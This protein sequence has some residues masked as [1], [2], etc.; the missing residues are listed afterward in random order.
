MWDKS[1][2]RWKQLTCGCAKRQNLKSKLAL[3]GTGGSPSKALQSI[4]LK[5]AFLFGVISYELAESSERF[6]RII[7]RSKSPIIVQYGNQTI[8]RLLLK[9][10]EGPY[11]H[12]LPICL[13]RP[14]WQKG[15]ALGQSRSL[16][17][18]FLIP[19]LDGPGFTKQSH[20]AMTIQK[21]KDMLTRGRLSW[22]K[23]G[24]AYKGC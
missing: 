8:K 3:S 7:A 20:C 18:P 2:T 23:Q 15:S 6:T 12:A 1:R 9:D 4:I 21:A 10:K 19:I 24:S 5:A 22:E 11:T 17:Y 16:G 14:L 13:I